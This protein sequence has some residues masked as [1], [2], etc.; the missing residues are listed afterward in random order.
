MFRTLSPSTGRSDDAVLNGIAQ[1][2]QQHNHEPEYFEA[3]RDV[4]LYPPERPG[5]AAATRS[6]QQED[7]A[8]NPADGWPCVVANMISK[9]AGPLQKDLLDERRLLQFV[10]EWCETHSSR[11][12]GVAFADASLFYDRSPDEICTFV[13]PSPSNNIYI[14]IPHAVRD[15]VLRV[16]Q[17]CQISLFTAPKVCCCA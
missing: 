6:R 2:L 10:V 11:Q 3:C 14:R 8:P 1:T 15:P 17:E 13:D 4:A 7:E 16:A 12:A 9:I 5:R